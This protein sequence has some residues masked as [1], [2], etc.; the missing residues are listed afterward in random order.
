MGKKWKTEEEKVNRS[1]NSKRNK[2]NSTNVL[3]RRIQNLFFF[4]IDKTDWYMINARSASWHSHNEMSKQMI[5][6]LV[7][8]DLP[9]SFKILTFKS[10]TFCLFGKNDEKPVMQ[11]VQPII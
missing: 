4:N 1:K 10:V 11:L 8:N 6:H 5:P 2:T 3:R 9:Q 7:W